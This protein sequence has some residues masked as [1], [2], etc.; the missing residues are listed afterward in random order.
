MVRLRVPRDRKLL[1]RTTERRVTRIRAQPLRPLPA[2]CSE[3]PVFE[4]A[5]PADTAPSGQAARSP[6]NVH[7]LSFL[8]REGAIVV[9]KYLQRYPGVIFGFMATAGLL[10]VGALLW[11]EKFSAMPLLSVLVVPLILAGAALGLGMGHDRLV[12]LHTAR[13]LG[14][15]GGLF[16]G[17]VFS[18]ALLIGPVAFLLAIG[19]PPAALLVGI[20]LGHP[21]TRS[22]ALLAATRSWPGE[23]VES[24]SG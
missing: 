7:H 20:R 22:G 12:P 23:V 15:A 14:I 6:D 13:R 2:L 10:K 19:G 24:S 16:F 17:A 1:S 11:Q 5:L 4:G 21:Q 18:A 8:Q 3:R 9:N